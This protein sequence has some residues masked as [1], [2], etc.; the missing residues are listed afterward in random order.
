[1]PFVLKAVGQLR[2][3]YYSSGDDVDRS[4]FQRSTCWLCGGPEARKA[5][6]PSWYHR[7]VPGRGGTVGTGEGGVRARELSGGKAVIGVITNPPRAATASVL[8][9]LLKHRKKMPVLIKCTY[10]LDSIFEITFRV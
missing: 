2:K 7:K 6:I 5:V 10:Y 9:L 8:E 1:M 4:A 3:E